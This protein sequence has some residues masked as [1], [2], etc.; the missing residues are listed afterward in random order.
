MA[1]LGIGDPYWYEWYVG[2]KSVIDMLNPDSRIVSVTFQHGDFDTVDDV[3][4]EFNDSGCQICYQIKHEI[5]TSK[6]SNLTFGKLLEKKEN[7]K[8]LIAAIFFGWQSAS[9]N[10]QGTI[11][12][13][14]YTNRNIGKNKTVREYNGTS[15][16]AYPLD[17]FLFSIKKA[18]QDV[19][20]AEKINIADNN[21]KLQWEEL[22]RNINSDKASIA[23]FLKIFTVESGQLGLEDLEENLIKSLAASFSCSGSLAL[24]LFKNLVFA[25]REWT[26]TRRVNEKVTLEEAY[27]ALAVE[28][29]KNEAQH[30]L[31]YPT[32]FFESR[33]VFC[34]NIK[35]QLLNTNKKV[36]FI[37]G[38]PGSGKT[39]TISFIQS[40][41]NLFLLRYH[42]FKPISPHQHFYNVDE[43]ICSAENLWGTL[44]IQLR[45]RLH[46]K[47]A[48]YNVPINN[49]MLT[50]E[51]M[52]AHV[53]R[54]LGIIA[55]NNNERVF[56]CIDGIDHAARAKCQVSFLSSLYLPSEIPNNVCFVIVGQPVSMY[57]SQYPVWLHNQAF[58]KQI[59]YID[60]PKL[61]QIDIKQLILASAVQLSSNSEELASFIFNRTQGNNLSAVYAVEEIKMCQSLESAIDKLNI[62]GVTDDVQLYY[63]HLWSFA[64]EHINKMGLGVIFPESIIACPILLMNGRINIRI[65]SRA[66]DYYKISK[67]DWKIIFDS[68]NPVIV[69]C[70][71]DEYA[72]FHNDFR[73]FLMGVISISGYQPRYEEIALALA[74]DLLKND[75]GLLSYV[76]GITLLQCA[77]KC[78]LVPKYF[79]SDFIINALAVGISQDRLDDFAHIAYSEACK[80]KDIELFKNVYLSIKTLHQHR[81]YFEYYQKEYKCVDFPEMS[82][83]DIAEMRSL[84]LSKD[85]LIEYENTLKLCIKLYNANVIDG[86]LR[87]K[88]LYER[89]FS[90]LS[91]CSFLSLCV[92]KVSDQESWELNNNEVGTF[93]KFWGES[94]AKIN[95]RVPSI[96][97]PN[98]NLENRAQIIFGDEYFVNCLNMGLV[99]LALEV[100]TKGYVSQRCFIENLEQIY[101]KNYTKKFEPF[102]FHIDDVSEPAWGRLFALAIAGSIKND[103]KFDDSEIR[104]K[105]EIKNI[106]EENS[107]LLVVAAF[108][109]GLRENTLDDAV[110]CGHIK[111]NLNLLEDDYR[112]VNQITKL[113]VFAALLGKYYWCAGGPSKVF[114]DSLS[115]FLTTKLFRSFDYSKAR[116]FLLFTFL[117]SGISMHLASDKKFIEDLKIS[118]FDIDL[119]GMYYKVHILDYLIKIDRLDLVKEYILA[120]YGENGKKIC[121]DEYRNEAHTIFCEYGKLVMPDLMDTVSANL[122]WDVVGYV[123][124]KEY[125]MHGLSDSF[126][127]ITDKYPEKWKDYGIRLYKQSEIAKIA[128]N[129]YAY[130]IRNSIIKA[131]VKNGYKDFWNLGLVDDEFR[132]NPDA[133][134]NSIFTFIDTAQNEYDLKIIWLCNCGIHSW[135]TDNDR[136]ASINIYN[137]CEEKCGKLNIN[138]HQLVAELTPNWIPILEHSKKQKD[139]DVGNVDE[140][141]LKRNKEKEDIIEEYR[142]RSVKSVL[143]ED[144]AIIPAQSNHPLRY[145][146]ILDMLEKENLLNR[147]TAELLLN[148]ICIYIKDSLWHLQSVE[149]T[150]KKLLNVLEEEAFWK[151]AQAL[152][153]HLSEYDYQSSVRDIQLL[154]KLYFESNDLEIQKLFEQELSAQEEWTTGNNHIKV[155]EISL[156]SMNTFDSPNS[157]CELVLYILLTQLESQNACKVETAIFSIYLLGKYIDETQNILALDWI[158]F[159]ELHKDYLLIPIA[160]W[161]R[162]EVISEELINVL[163][164]E[165][166]NCNQLTRKYY[167]HSVLVEKLSLNKD[168]IDFTAKEKKYSLPLIG[169]IEQHPSIEQFLNLSDNN[170]D[171][172]RYIKQNSAEDKFV[173]DK[174][175]HGTYIR[176]PEPNRDVERIIYGKEK[177][178]RWGI[179][180][181]SVKKCTLIS[182]EDIFMLTEMPKIIYDDKWFPVLQDEYRNKNQSSR[183]SEQELTNIANGHLH[184][185]EIMLAAC[186]WYPW[187]SKEGVIYKTNAKVSI[188]NAIIK[189]NKN[190]LSIGNFGLLSRSDILQEMREE[191]LKYGG[192]NLFNQSV[193]KMRFIFGNSQFVPSAFMQLCFGCSPKINN[194]YILCNESGVEVVRFERIASPTRDLIQQQYFRQP[195]LF[196]WICNKQWLSDKLQELNL[197]L[198]FISQTDDMQLF[199]K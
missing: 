13:K 109:T 38:E 198:W 169:D 184:E 60:M 177:E 27:S 158:N 103:I 77:N 182:N 160:R 91:P 80:A 138:F 86:K 156:I 66:L 100:A 185:N 51:D 72:L 135:Y 146:L 101:Y 106:Y 54:L 170:D 155:D 81:R 9:K 191:F 89:W 157:L 17:I 4:V 149:S 42:T 19:S 63:D 20:D 35:E 120:L 159:S 196:R 52:R 48:A 186:I 98:S 150:V 94:A 165:Y 64:S 139:T 29:D 174:Y 82:N 122:K 16:T 78:E 74:T 161:E 133:I 107:F 59:E 116:K 7:K 167:L 132:L 136:N 181:L 62:S 124:H 71:G 153:E 119:L 21:L 11:A 166:Q 3:V 110:I 39:S 36:V 141:Q 180:P 121:L 87:A 69:H 151:I 148:S 83:I 130:E 145:K 111:G 76:S 46:G 113:T 194:P 49:K 73:V 97:K 147:E 183:L 75:E 117:N 2:L 30:R 6:E 95:Q 199:I 123:G 126:D 192:I 56:V 5:S 105:K 37:S 144:Y 88:Q 33:K 175:E 178:G 70:G 195:I 188:H 134:Y 24:E 31:A 152:I 96:S 58:E 1:T 118:L 190:N 61:D 79:T 18:L 45:E 93:L 57:R 162:E 172:R 99:D 65:L 193:G 28:K 108:L 154:L 187:N 67:S 92:G 102:L 129:G 164:N 137:A 179:I 114:H 125:A 53:C 142:L 8:S 168:Q 12:P 112:I 163:R 50:V 32:P 41:Y 127:M 128:D 55:S 22:C 189:N 43:G 23:E 85:N 90:G 140:Y 115:W 131:A 14:L 40:K 68:L 25:L 176:I 47:L 197:N 84:P 15:Y 34:E 143:S 26:T 104:I 44:L 10:A 171:I 173:E